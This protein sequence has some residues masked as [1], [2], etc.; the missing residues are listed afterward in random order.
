MTAAEHETPTE[1]RPET[2]CPSCPHPLE[3]HD[4]IA[5]R[6]CAATAVGN[7]ER[8]CVCGAAKKAQH[9]GR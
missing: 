6:Y 7:T 3:E 8:G 5:R 4:V 1:V 2:S 9:R